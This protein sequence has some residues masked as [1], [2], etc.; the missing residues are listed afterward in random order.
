[1]SWKE[2]L[3]GKE[4]GERVVWIWVWE[5]V[6][7]GLVCVCMTE[8]GERQHPSQPNGLRGNLTT[9]DGL[10]LRIPDTVVLNVGADRL[11][12]LPAKPRIHLR[13]RGLIGCLLENEPDDQDERPAILLRFGFVSPLDDFIGDRVELLHRKF[14]E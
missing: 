13:P 11:H 4:L 12:H 9:G 10:S 5:L 1:M 3:V 14:V 6:T 8:A 2:G 7:S